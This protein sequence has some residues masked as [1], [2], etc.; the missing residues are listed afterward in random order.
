MAN[1]NF[2]KEK[3]KKY[4]HIAEHILTQTYPL[5]KDTKILLGV[6][7]NIYK[8]TI[9]TIELILKYERE[10]KRIPPYHETD[11]SK[12]NMFK[13]KIIEHYHMNIKFLTLIEET[14]DIIKKHKESPVEF[15]RKDK[16]VICSE[17]YNLRTISVEEMKKFI[18][19]SQ[20]FFKEINNIIDKNK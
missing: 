14:A 11:E 4:N 20:I 17:K 18:K 1:Y 9:T 3:A 7:N 16:F 10:K 6:I 5:V 12:I 8:A 2:L 13:W 19:T 15:T